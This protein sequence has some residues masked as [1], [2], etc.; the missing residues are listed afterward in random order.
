M[1]GTSGISVMN[2][3]LQTGNEKRIEI[4][5]SRET[6]TEVRAMMAQI[7]VDMTYEELL[8]AFIRLYQTYPDQVEKYHY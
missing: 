1:S 7:D 3:D 4:H 6:K 8:H 5:C 2:S